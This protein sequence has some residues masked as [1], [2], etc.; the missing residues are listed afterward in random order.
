MIHGLDIF[1]CLCLQ[2]GVKIPIT[3]LQGTCSKA[4]WFDFVW[5]C[6]LRV[7]YDH[8]IHNDTSS[9]QTCPARIIQCF[10]PGM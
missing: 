9:L 2:V 3:L 4:V 10:S 8:D 6:P 5:G 1:S 7:I